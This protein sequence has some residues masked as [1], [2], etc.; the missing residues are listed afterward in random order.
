MNIMCPKHPKEI[1]HVTRYAILLGKKGDRYATSDRT[2]WLYCVKCD[3]M[4]K[5]KMTFKVSIR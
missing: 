3:K 5:P 1:L 2:G 4:Y